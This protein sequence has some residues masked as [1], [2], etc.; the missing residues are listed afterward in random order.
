MDDPNLCVIVS[1]L[2][3][4][5]SIP[6]LSWRTPFRVKRSCC[7][8][9]TCKFEAAPISVNLSES[10]SSD[11]STYTISVVVSE[12]CGLTL[13]E[14]VGGDDHKT[15]FCAWSRTNGESQQKYWGFDPKCTASASRPVFARV[16]TCPTTED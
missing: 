10:R 15:E 13:S 1:S 7:G 8:S 4:I 5:D 2:L 12:S 11:C 6:F 14:S 9:Q 16:A 3:V